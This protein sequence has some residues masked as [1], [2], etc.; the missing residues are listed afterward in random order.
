VRNDEIRVRLLGMR[1]FESN[2]ASS[3]SVIAVTN[4]AGS[5]YDLKQIKPAD[6]DPQSNSKLLCRLPLFR[7]LR[8][9]WLHR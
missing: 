1:G 9:I 2:A 4:Q 7:L 5:G 6:N 8:S 3:V